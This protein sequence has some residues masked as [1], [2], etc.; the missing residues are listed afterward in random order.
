MELKVAIVANKEELTIQV[1]YR[2]RR[3]LAQAGIPEDPLQ[4]TIVISVGGDGTLLSAF[5]QYEA[6]LHQ[7][8]F[9]GV[10]TGH[11]GFYTDWRDYE[12]AEMVASLQNEEIK[13][14]SYPLLEVKIGYALSLIHI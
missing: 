3:L 13:S 9:I 10:H 1:V 14:I 7:V 6:Q 11:L 12:L 2:L 5:H 8:R 4:P